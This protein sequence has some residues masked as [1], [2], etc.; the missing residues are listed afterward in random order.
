M[1]QT[2]PAGRPRPAITKRRKIVAGV[3]RAG[4]P[5]KVI[6]AMARFSR[7]ARQA[8][9]RRGLPSA[10][11]IV[12]W[13]CF[14]VTVPL[15]P[16]TVT[17][18]LSA[19]TPKPLSIGP[20]HTVVPRTPIAATGVRICTFAA[21]SPSI[22]PPTYRKLAARAGRVIDEFVDH[23]RRAFAERQ[24]SAV[25]Q[26]RLKARAFSTAA[27]IPEIDVRVDNQ[28]T[29]PPGLRGFNLRL[30]L[31]N[32]ANGRSRVRDG[33]AGAEDADGQRRRQPANC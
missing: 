31:V 21:G 2:L 22:R 8:A 12:P 16:V 25:F 9:A 32:C 15:F 14:R 7:P 17:S 24:L 3:G 10:K 29:R 20:P 4:D 6:E 18:P 23:E 28:R 33:D 11:S 5:P 1:P 26:R 13:P 30:D 27:T 19:T